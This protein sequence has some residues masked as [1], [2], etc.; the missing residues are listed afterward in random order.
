MI[1]NEVWISSWCMPACL[2]HRLFIQNV[3]CVTPVRRCQAAASLTTRCQPSAPFNFRCQNVPPAVQL[4]S[5]GT[6]STIALKT[7]RN[8]V[9]TRPAAWVC[10]V[11]VIYMARALLQSTTII[12]V[13]IV[14]V[15]IIAN[16][17]R[18]ILSPSFTSF[19]SASTTS[20]DA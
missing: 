16:H 3:L 7:A 1:A 19:F 12:I 8:A 4:G 17:L 13:I 9:E 6:R 18:T 11:S 10:W 5:R 20:D 2:L 14:V 15:V